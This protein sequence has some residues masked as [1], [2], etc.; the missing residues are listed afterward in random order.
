MV[1]LAVLLLAMEIFFDILPG[2]SQV[3]ISLKYGTQF[4]CFHHHTHKML[5]NSMSKAERRVFNTLQSTAAVIDYLDSNYN[6]STAH[7][8]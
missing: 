2:C 6:I 3:D 5:E 8:D 7:P 4:Q 1:S